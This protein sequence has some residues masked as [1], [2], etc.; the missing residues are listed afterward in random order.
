M[1]VAG[2][3][4]RILLFGYYRELAGTSEMRLDLPACSRV[5]DLV[6]DIRSDPLFSSIPA[7]PVIA[8]N[9]SFAPASHVLSS[10]DEIALIPPMSGG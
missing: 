9:R 3:Q 5:E 1:T 4:I 6:A 2:V 7:T 10:D 8:V